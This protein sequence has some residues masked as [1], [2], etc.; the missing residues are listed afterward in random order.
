MSVHPKQDLGGNVYSDGFNIATAADDTYVTGASVD[1]KVG[2]TPLSCLAVINPVFTSASGAGGATNTLEGQIQTDDNSAFS[3][4]TQVGSTYTYVYTWVSNGLN[5]GAHVVEQDLSGA[6]QYVR[7]RAKLT[8]SGT[9]TI[10]GQTISGHLVLGG[11]D[12]VPT[13]AKTDTDGA[14]EATVEP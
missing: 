5:G 8:E 7:W 10:S 12:Q 14:Y 1:R 6:E 13:P 11:F 4:P 2:A 9:I 3:S